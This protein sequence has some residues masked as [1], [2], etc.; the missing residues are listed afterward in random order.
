MKKRIL[1]IEDDPC[2]IDIYE[3][4]FRKKGDFIVETIK[5][6]AEGLE[7]IARIRE[8]KDKRPDLILLD[9]ILPDRNGIE[10]LEEIRRQ[11][12]IKDLRVFILTNFTSLE[13]KEM[14]VD[15]KADYLVK[16]DYTPVELV[17]LIKERL[18]Q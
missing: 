8:G 12:G 16:T 15:L 4:S 13:F 10:I 11:N 18:A 17:K 1:L 9:L 5:T 2:L 14:G 7:K 3:F 6:G